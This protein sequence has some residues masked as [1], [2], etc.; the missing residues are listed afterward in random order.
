MGAP[1]AGSGS[2]PEFQGVSAHKYRY[3]AL[4]G[5][6]SSIYNGEVNFVA[7]GGGYG[8]S[9]VATYPPD[10]GIAGNGGCGGG[11]GAYNGADFTS[12]GQAIHGDDFYNQ[13]TNGQK[14]LET[15]VI[16]YGWNGGNSTS[17]HYGSGGGGAGSEG[18]VAGGTTNF[19]HGGNG[20]QCDIMGTNYYWSGGGGG[21]GY[22]NIGGNGGL[23]GGGGGA[24]GTTTGGTGGIN[25]GFP[26]GGGAISAHAD[27]P[28]GNGG[29]HTGGGGG[30]G[31]HYDSTNQGGNGGSGIVVIKYKLY[32]SK[33]YNF[34]NT[35]NATTN[36]QLEYINKSINM[37][38]PFYNY[39]IITKFDEYDI[40]FDNNTICDILLSNNKDYI[41]L[42]NIE[43]YKNHKLI[44][45]N[46][47]SKFDN[48]NTDPLSINHYTN[49]IVWYKFD[50]NLNNSSHSGVGSLTEGGTQAQFISSNG[51]YKFGKSALVNN[52]ILTIPNFHFSNLI[53]GLTKSFTISFWFKANSISGTWNVLFDA[54]DYTNNIA[55][56]RVYINTN[57]YLY[58][59][60]YNSGFASDYTLAL[61]GD[62][63]DNNWRL[64]TF[65]WTYVSHSSDVYTYDLRFYED[66]VL[67]GDVD[68]QVIKSD[69]S[70]GFQ[71]GH[72]D[73]GTAY[74]M[75]GYYDD[76]R[77]YDKALTQEEISNLY[78]YNTLFPT[79]SINDYTNLIAWY[80]FDDNLNNSAHSIIGSLAETG[81]P[82]QFINS[83]DNY[84]FGKSALV[85]NTILT[86]PDFHFSNLTHGL[87]KSFTIS[88]W[89][90]ANSISGTWNILF[91]A[92]DYATS[93]DRA[94]IRVYI[95]NTT[96]EL[97]YVS[98]NGS[99]S[100]S[101]YI[102]SLDG[103]FI[104]NKWRLYTFT[105]TYNSNSSDIYSYDIRFYENGVLNN[106]VDTQSIK[107]IDTHGFQIGDGNPDGTYPIEGYYDDFRIYD[108]ALSQTE[109]SNLYNY[110]TL[111]PTL[112]IIDDNTNLILYYKFDDD[113]NDSSGNG[114]T[115]NIS[116]GTANFE[117][118]SI[119]L[120]SGNICNGTVANPTT[121]IPDGKTAISITYWVNNI[122]SS[123]SWKL[124]FRLRASNIYI[125]YEN[126]TLNFHLEGGTIKKDIGAITTFTHVSISCN[127]NDWKLYLDGVLQTA[128]DYD[129]SSST[130]LQNGFTNDSS[131]NTFKWFKDTATDQ[132]YGQIKDF[133][134]YDKALSQT[135]ISNLYYH[136][137]FLIL[138][139]KFDADTNDSSGNGH[140]INISSG[141]ANFENNSI[142]LK[143]GN[144][145]NGTVANPTTVIPDGKTAI[146]ITYW[147][148]N[149]TSSGSWKLLFRL[150]ASNIYIYYENATLNFHL[151][152][153]TIKKDIGA[154][155]TF[156]HVSIS[157]NGNDWKL[158]LDGVLQTALDYDTSSSTT[159]QNGFTNDS[160]D[161]TFK[162]FKDTATD[163]FY[164]QI[165]DF[166]IYD[167]ALSQTEISNLYNYNTL[168]PTLPVNTT[169]PIV[170]NLPY[171]S[172]ITGKSEIYS[173]PLCIIKYKTEYDYATNYNIKD[174][175]YHKF[176]IITPQ[177][178][179]NQLVTDAN[180]AVDSIPTYPNI[181]SFS[182]FY[183]MPEPAGP[184]SPVATSTSATIYPNSSHGRPTGS[185]NGSDG[186]AYHIWMGGFAIYNT[187]AQNA[188]Y[189]NSSFNKLNNFGSQ[190][191]YY[192]PRDYRSSIVMA[193]VGDSMTVNIQSGTRGNYNVR[194]HV[195]IYNNGWTRVTGSGS[196][197]QGGAATITRTFYFNVPNIPPGSYLIQFI[198]DYYYSSFHGASY[199]ATIHIWE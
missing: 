74:P 124:L 155:T 80:K 19:A 24:A 41:S 67:N 173:S 174:V 103:D 20:I 149:I 199:S 28:G 151:E 88:F 5:V 188:G 48:Y 3:R 44:L 172:S 97:V 64:Y 167:K 122:T 33:Y 118:N 131:D 91:D 81:T 2:Y 51:Y 94:G 26:G 99:S 157:C 18:N 42:T 71:I 197:S 198:C 140:T 32:N 192:T 183:G 62:F 60:Y 90:K 179:D 54:S 46:N 123:G 23:G 13:I 37:I 184:P 77:I 177:S 108:K 121:V 63:T 56:I 75:E 194:C 93:S 145:C 178:N 52:T 70:N 160:S 4:K 6:N 130:T 66:S 156:T 196:V 47:S 92:S 189:S 78:N 7:Q 86:I 114:H 16:V 45:T 185:D 166:R 14:T 100:S 136:H 138:Y 11:V 12:S 168:F 164:G 34:D 137:S 135:E 43:L 180:G 152:G 125:Y 134:I 102:S 58:I 143:S 105:Y 128:L 27:K 61:N 107:Y 38:D 84:K 17:S 162:W 106:G 119:Y 165:K 115:I 89:F 144:I 79:I 159:L 126:A 36:E 25:N 22:S 21:S 141:T 147:V 65:V 98:Y 146:S 72:G 132:F 163:Q 10:G 153:G 175:W 112:S 139:Y 190:S 49:L 57:N 76:F 150:R 169:N 85:N 176:N 1:K 96:K 117:N 171:T 120:K 73:Q 191:G 158:Y 111:F 29:R 59:Y 69:S 142:Y 95:K 31:G 195:F 87:T 181:L 116:S 170:Y 83:T 82:A 53:Q 8:S 129:T 30:G 68:R 55:G 187:T 110:N 39:L 127:G 104:D 148:N 133:R 113:T 40:S 182:N 154:I 101:N 50:D 161:N 193:Q 109:I 186:Y 15:G 9:S 35:Y